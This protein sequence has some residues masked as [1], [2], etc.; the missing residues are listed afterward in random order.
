MKTTAGFLA[1][2]VPDLRWNPNHEKLPLLIL[3]AHS[4]LR[5]PCYFHFVH[6]MA[7]ETNSRKGKI[8]LK[9]SRLN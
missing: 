9:H 7:P 4:P 2:T 8:E 3:E 1:S 5:V 6:E